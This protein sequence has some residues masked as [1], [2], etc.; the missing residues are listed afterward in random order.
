MEGTVNI[1]DALRKLG[2]M[3]RATPRNTGAMGNPGGRGAPVVQYPNST[4]HPP[5]LSELDLDKKTS[6]LA[7]KL[8]DLPEEQFEAVKS[9]EATM[10]VAIR[11]AAKQRA[12]STP[13]PSLPT[14]IYDVIYADPPW[15]YDNQIPQWGPTSLHYPEMELDKIKALELPVADN[16]VLFLWVTNP[17]LDSALEV[18]DAWGF[19]YKTNMVWVKTELKR[20]GSGFYV[21]GRHELLFICTRGSKVPDQRGKEPIGSVMEA[22]VGEH[23][24]KPHIFYNIIE[25]MYPGGNYLELFARNKRDG[26]TAWGNESETS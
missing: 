7:Q 5:T 18:V 4:A 21:R 17:M 14:G 22:P 9:G 26:W 8:V 16:S 2:E 24:A 20:P 15:A 19:E 10:S 11:Q 12:A 25:T 3:L 13:T 6:A 23:S 1:M